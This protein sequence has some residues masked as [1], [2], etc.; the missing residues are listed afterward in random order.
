MTCFYFKQSVFLYLYLSR[1]NS[2]GVNKKRGMRSGGRG[3]SGGH[4]CLMGSGQGGGQ[5]GGGH[6]GLGGGRERNWPCGGGGV[7]GGRWLWGA[8]EVAFNLG[9]VGSQGR[10]GQ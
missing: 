9:Q 5:D 1:Y 6:S 2:N 3:R 7:G 8:A 10:E 4:N